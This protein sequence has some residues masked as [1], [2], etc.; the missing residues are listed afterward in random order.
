MRNVNDGRSEEEPEGTQ[1]ELEA[2]PPLREIVGD[3]VYDVWVAMLKKL[4]RCVVQPRPR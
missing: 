3:D 4:V 2:P 1:E